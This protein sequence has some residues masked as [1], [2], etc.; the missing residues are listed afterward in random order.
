M[1]GPRVSARAAAEKARTPTAS[2]PFIRTPIHPDSRNRHRSR[3][4][5]SIGRPRASLVARVQSFLIDDLSCHI[6]ASRSIHSGLFSRLFAAG[7]H[8]AG[9]LQETRTQPH[10]PQIPPKYRSVATVL[11]GHMVPTATAT[12]RSIASGLVSRS[13]AHGCF[14]ATT[15]TSAVP[16]GEATSRG[17]GVPSSGRRSRTCM[18]AGNGREM[19]RAYGVPSRKA[20]PF[21]SAEVSRHIRTGYTGRTCSFSTKNR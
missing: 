17:V 4:A 13:Y 15:F 10:L 14:K 6:S 9:V 21:F 8:V 18:H 19:T 2:S 1:H 3:L 7:P 11:P 5:L 20:K 16:H 12:A